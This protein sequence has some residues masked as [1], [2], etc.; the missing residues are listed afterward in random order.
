[1]KAVSPMIATVLLIAFTVA[2]G[3]LLIAWYPSL[4]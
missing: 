3:G 2:V 1:M 4:F